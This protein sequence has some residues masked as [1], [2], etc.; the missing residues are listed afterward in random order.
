[1]EEIFL[2]TLITPEQFVEIMKMNRDG[3]LSSSN[4]KK[5]IE[6]T[7]ESNRKVLVENLVV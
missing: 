3:L 4:T 7:R 2:K 5:L 6:L 1:M